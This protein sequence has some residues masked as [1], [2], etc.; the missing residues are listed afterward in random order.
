M[1]FGELPNFM[2]ETPP[3]AK[4]TSPFGNPHNTGFQRAEPFGRRRLLFNQC[5]NSSE[6]Y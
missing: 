2:G 3:A 1:Y 6:D 5:W 4:G